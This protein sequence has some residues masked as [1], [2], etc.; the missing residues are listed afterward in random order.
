MMKENP[1][2]DFVFGLDIGTRNVVGT[3]G[4]QAEDGF[5]VVAQCVREHQT[6]AMLDGQIHDIGRVGDT[7]REVKEVLEEQLGI[8]LTQV[9]IAAAGRVLRTVTTQV[10]YEYPEETVVSGE[11]LHTLDLM[12]I[13]QAQQELLAEGDNKYKFYCVGYSVMKYYLND[14]LFSSL[15][16]HKANKIEEVII[17]T[18]LPEDVVDGLYSAVERA[19]LQVANLTLE[20]IAAINVAIPENFR[21]LNIALV[22]VGAGTSDICITRDGSIIAY[23]MI[24]FAGDELTEVIVQSYLVDFATAEQIKLDSSSMEE[25]TYEDIMGISHTV[26]A[27]EVWKLTEVVREKMTTEV[28]TKIRELNGDKSV[29]AAFIVGGGGKIHGYTDSLAKKLDIVPERVAL[30]GEEVMKSIIFEQENIKKDPLLVTPIGICLNYYE[31]KNNFI[32]IHF[33]GEMMKLYDNG[34][35]TVVDAA[36]QAGFTTEE[37]FPRRGR[38]IHFTVNGTP[39]MIRGGEGESAIVKMNGMT[40]GMNTPLEFNCDIMIE[41]STA[42]EEAAC[43]IEELDEYSGSTMTFEVCGKHIRCPKFMEVNGSLEPGSYEIQEGD[44]IE[45]RS[46]YTVGQLAEFMDVEIDPDRE[47]LVN[48]RPATMDSL[49]Y[50]NFSIDWTVLSFGAAP[51]APKEKTSKASSILDQL[52]YGSKYG[53]GAK[54]EDSAAEDAKETT[55]EVNQVEESDTSL[56]YTSE[57]VE[58]ETTSDRGMAEEVIPDEMEGT[59]QAGIHVTVNQEP[60][61]LSGK[62]NYIFVDIFNVIDFDVQAGGGR[63]IVTKINGATCGYSDE[64]HEGDEI[65]VYW[66]EL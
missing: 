4:Y 60:V 20:P 34:R 35:L 22:D 33:N 7:I 38:E 62:S 52:K 51:V 11:D 61:F 3:V 18:F 10:A 49:I 14:E 45:T 53:F 42:G 46:F 30:R 58:G 24:P 23:G 65:L 2:E 63:P 15:E 43:T 17:V 41:P 26:A 16:G 40:V 50:A 54:A 37:L 47:I 8:T 59:E 32:M 27:E 48:N 44:A 29:S 55:N 39:R 5:H 36:M 28:S 13:D 57:H 9:C 19:G 25:V 6:R 12:G 1:M 56:G 64:L 31:Q 21:M 66:K